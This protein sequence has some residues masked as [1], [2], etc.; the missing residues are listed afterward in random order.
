MQKW[1]PSG[2]SCAWLSTET[3]EVFLLSHLHKPKVYIET[4]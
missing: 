2:G 4:R 3:K 1:T